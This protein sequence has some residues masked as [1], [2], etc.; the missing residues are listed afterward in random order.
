MT[1][2]NDKFWEQPPKITEDPHVATV[3]EATWQISEQMMLVANAMIAYRNT[4]KAQ[5]VR[6]AE[7][8]K[9]LEFSKEAADRTIKHITDNNEFLRER[10][11]VTDSG[12]QVDMAPMLDALS[13]PNRD[14]EELEKLERQ[15]E[16]SKEDNG[17]LKDLARLQYKQS[18]QREGDLLNKLSGMKYQ[19]DKDKATI[20]A[21]AAALGRADAKLMEQTALSAG[22]DILEEDYEREREIT[23]DITEQMLNLGMKM[24]TRAKNV[25]RLATAATRH[26][27]R[28]NNVI[29][30][31]LL[32]PLRQGV[33]DAYGYEED[34]HLECST[35][36]YDVVETGVFAKH[37]E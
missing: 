8:E 10:I 34:A 19:R 25:T 22:A 4:V 23:R 20:E 2:V 12:V 28:G 32:A 1:S 29:A 26:L 11:A 5:A 27:R 30:E 13:P 6:I 24:G 17:K 16:F 7:L 31:Q 14:T 36:S 35:R 33:H 15:L 9:E 37:E 3:R 21:Y 18:Q